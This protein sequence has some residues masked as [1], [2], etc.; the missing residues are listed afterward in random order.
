M[1]IVGICTAVTSIF[2]NTFLPTSS[3]VMAKN[4]T[5]TYNRIAYDGT[6]F[7]TVFVCF[8]VFGLMSVSSDLLS[9]YVGDEYMYLVPW[10][11]V[12]IL[13]VLHNHILCI[14]SLILGGTN[15]KPLAQ[16]T[17]VAAVVA[18]IIA[19]LLIPELG[20]GGVAMGSVV[21]TISQQLFYYLY[22]FPRTMKINS[23]K[24]FRTTLLPVGLVGC[25]IWIFLDFIPHTNNH[26]VNVFVFGAM[27]AIIYFLFCFVYLNKEDKIYLFSLIKTDKSN[28][29]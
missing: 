2:F 26:W 23:W 12:F 1:G 9:L 21:Y 16:M 7:I 8:C 27:F 13:L 24:I 11:K 18:L 6:K 25:S 15:I 17:A 5:V 28:K 29:K 4:D 19:W 22:Y 10:L 20:I 3:K 14:S